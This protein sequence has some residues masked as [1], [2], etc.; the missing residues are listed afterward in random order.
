MALGRFEIGGRFRFIYRF[1]S[2]NHF[3]LGALLSLV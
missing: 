3:A 1:N 2:R